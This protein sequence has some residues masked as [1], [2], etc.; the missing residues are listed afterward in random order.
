MKMTSDERK[1]E[2]ERFIRE[3]VVEGFSL[4]CRVC[5]AAWTCEPT[6]G[7]TCTEV[8]REWALERPTDK[9]D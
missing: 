4:S 3:R 1:A 2:A 5:P 8:V 9:E 7:R 6:D